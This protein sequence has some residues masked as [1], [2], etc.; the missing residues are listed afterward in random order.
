VSGHQQ[1]SVQTLLGLERTP[2]AVG[3]FDVPPPGV[4]AWHTG[5]RGLRVLARGPRGKGILYD[6]AGPL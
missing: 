5:T 6:S 1:D 3:F 2:I 4:E